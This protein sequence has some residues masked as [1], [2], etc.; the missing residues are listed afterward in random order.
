M[1]TTKNPRHAHV[2]D[3]SDDSDRGAVI[4]DSI[5][6][7]P[8]PS[9]QANVST[10][11]SKDK[12]LNSEKTPEKMMPANIDLR[13]DSGYSSY[14]TASKSSAD[15]APSTSRHPPALNT[16]TAPAVPQSPAPKPRKSA[17]TAERQHS[18]ESSPRQKPSRTASIS[19]SSKRPAGQRRTTLTQGA[20]ECNDPNWLTCGPNV[21]LPHRRRQDSRPE[22]PPSMSSHN[23]RNIPSDLVSHSSDPNPYSP[24]SPT[25]TRQPAPYAAHG[26]ALVQTA[27][28]R[29][30][31]SATRPRPES[32]AGNPSASYWVPGMPNAYP[33][34]PQEP[35]G[36]PPANAAFHMQQHMQHM[37]NMQNMQ[38]PMPYMQQQPMSQ[39]GYYPQPQQYPSAQ[40]Y[41]H[42][43]RPPMSARGSSSQGPRSFPAPII[44]Q[45]IDEPASKYP[46]ARFAPPPTPVEQHH[47]QQNQM[48]LSYRKPKLIQ[49]SQYEDEDSEEDAFE[50]EEEYDEEYDAREEERRS[51]QDRALMPPPALRR[52]QSQR[53]PT[54]SQ[55]KTAPAVDRP[56]RRENRRKSIVV[57]DP[58]SARELEQDRPMRRQSVSRPAHRKAQSEYTTAQ[59]RVEVNNSRSNRRQSYQAYEMAQMEY[60]KARQAEALEEQ[61]KAERQREKRASRPVVRQ[62][63]PGQ[64]EDYDDD[65][66]QDEQPARP[67]R[68]R[69]TR[70]KTDAGEERTRKERLPE[71][72]NKRIVD[73]AEEYIMS[74]RGSRD[75]Y[76]DSINRAA[77]RESRAIYERS[78]SGSS[79]SDK[80]SQSNRT[81]MTSNTANELRLRIDTAQAIN[82]QLSG[83][84]DGR[85]LQLVPAGDGK[86]DLVIGNA[87]GEGTVYNSQRGSIMGTSS[88]SNRRSMIEGSRRREAEEVSERSFRSGR[89]RRDRDDEILQERDEQAQPLRR[90]RKTSYRH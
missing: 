77:K 23:V 33:S 24:P 87:R 29:R 67:L 6:R 72:K 71:P 14:T 88:N 10:K 47:Q 34:P 76:A 46:S 2:E 55:T 16:T 89:T 32:F 40:H 59:A 15:S 61:Y 31:S 26:P 85:T 82:V 73:A 27:R 19:S 63:M 4:N 12:E 44:T 79:G 43:Q 64:F 74:T 57:P 54:L 21:E 37:Q 13:S 1:A 39:G 58:I 83:D 20:E 3:C 17:G 35:R 48:R 53:R 66:E 49:A 45:A 28:T 42:P 52:G 84:M 75:P 30:P 36:P 68:A 9:A 7:K 51:R 90:T 70:R 50:G 22:M 65:E 5:P 86:T 60:A 25:Y 56:E 18:N 69:S 38:Y 78:A 81:T 62:R 41:D 11:R 8:S 80:Q